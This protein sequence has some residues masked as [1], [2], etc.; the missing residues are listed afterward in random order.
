M[1]EQ[2]IRCVYENPETGLVSE[3]KL[4]ERL[5]QYG[6]TH[7]NI[8]DFL[9]KQETYRKKKKTFKFYTPNEPFKLNCVYSFIMVNYYC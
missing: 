9:N 3:K 2:I 5:K 7:Q 8:R 6:I 4:Y 1:T